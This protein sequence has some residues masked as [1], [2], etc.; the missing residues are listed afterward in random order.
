[1][2]DPSGDADHL[3]AL[4]GA[5]DANVWRAVRYGDAPPQLRVTRPAVPVIGETIT[6]ICA[7]SGPWFRS[8]TG[9]LMAPCGDLDGAV[10][11]IERTLGRLVQVRS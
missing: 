6:V 1:M 2:G 11:H 10:E 8:S 5:L 3:D 7:P 9:D 4:A